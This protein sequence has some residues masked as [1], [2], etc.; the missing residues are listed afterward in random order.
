M[1]LVRGLQVFALLGCLSIGGAAGAQS[2]SQLRLVDAGYFAMPGFEV[3]AFSNT[4]DGNFS[5]SKIAGIEFIHHGVRTATNG[6]VRLSPTPEQW[7]P[8]PTMKSRE[9]RGQTI[10]TRLAYEAQKFEYEI[11]VEPRAEGVVVRVHL[12]R[13]LPPEL[14][15]KAGFNLEFLPTAYFHRGYLLDAKSGTLPLYPAGPTGLATNGE[16]ERLPLARG[17]RLVLAPEDAERR[18][19]IES[20][21]AE[22]VAPR[23][24]C[25]L[26]GWLSPECAQGRD[27]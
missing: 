25:S 21:N 1:A 14:V 11:S 27:H 10:V 4:Y 7:D 5:D 26:T 13:D 2:S 12:D 8:V 22:L 16:V 17:K 24:D 20:N 23:D 18:V 15:G 6:D 9:V 3:L 19:T